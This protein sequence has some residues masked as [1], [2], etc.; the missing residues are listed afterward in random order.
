MLVCQRRLAL[1]LHVAWQS[2][3]IKLGMEQV[4]MVGQI[5]AQHSFAWHEPIQHKKETG[6][7]NLAMRLG[8]QVPL[9]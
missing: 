8:V 5:V 1:L 6:A 3:D 7:S 2:D 4:S 9:L